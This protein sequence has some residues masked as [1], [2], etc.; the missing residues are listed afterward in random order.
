MN[1]GSVRVNVTIG[2]MLFDNTVFQGFSQRKSK[3]KLLS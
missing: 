1:A 3:P 2:I